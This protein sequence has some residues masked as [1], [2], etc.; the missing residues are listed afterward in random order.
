MK[1]LMQSLIKT[2]A[3]ENQERLDPIKG[4]GWRCSHSQLRDIIFV[5]SLAKHKLAT[6]T[7]LPSTCASGKK[8]VMQSL[9]EDSSNSDGY[10]ET[11]SI[12][13]E[14]LSS[15]VKPSNF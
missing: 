2:N 4:P 12:L 13:L 11:I 5:R 1:S 15:K 6:V 8:F 3:Q 7:F 14:I 10:T 9:A